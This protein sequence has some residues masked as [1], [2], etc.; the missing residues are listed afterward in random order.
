MITGNAEDTAVGD[1]IVIKVSNK[2]PY[3]VQLIAGLVAYSS[4]V[5][6]L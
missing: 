3:G 4:T 2:G 6:V 1:N 5:T